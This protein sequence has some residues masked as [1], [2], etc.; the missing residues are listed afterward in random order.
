MAESMSEHVA[1]LA[2]ALRGG[3]DPDGADAAVQ[4]DVH[5]GIGGGGDAEEG[6]AEASKA[7]EEREEEL[8]E[9]A[10]DDIGAGLPDAPDSGGAL[11]LQAQIIP[12]NFQ[13]I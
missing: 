8:L 5:E 6:E 12:P 13:N 10:N 7:E 9:G 1:L 3:V 11:T 2:P 4:E